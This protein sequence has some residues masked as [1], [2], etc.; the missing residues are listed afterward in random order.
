MAVKLHEE[1]GS[2]NRYWIPVPLFSPPHKKSDLIPMY[3]NIFFLTQSYSYNFQSLSQ[4]LRANGSSTPNRHILINYFENKST[5]SY[6]FFWGCCFFVSRKIDFLLSPHNAAQLRNAEEDWCW[7]DWMPTLAFM[8]LLL[9]HT[10]HENHLGYTDTFSPVK[11]AAKVF[12][13]AVT[14]ESGVH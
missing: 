9:N 10:H 5:L 11:D 3:K 1:S 7:W 8:K 14:A 12:A 2:V 13:A 4:E 6:L